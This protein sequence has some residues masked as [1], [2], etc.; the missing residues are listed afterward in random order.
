MHYTRTIM[1][2]VP[3]PPLQDF[4]TL[5]HKYIT[6]FQKSYWTKYMCVC[7]LIF[8]TNLSEN[9]LIPRRIE[10]DGQKMYTGLHVLFLI[11]VLF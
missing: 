8:S 7:V 6:I 3:C 11:L 5:S 1:S 2:S 4:S 10:R 9:F